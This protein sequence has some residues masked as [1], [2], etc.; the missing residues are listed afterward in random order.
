MHKVIPSPT[1][2]IN[3]GEEGSHEVYPLASKVERK[4]PPGKLEPS[5]SCC[6][7]SLPPNSSIALPEGV[8]VKKE[9]CFSAV[10]PI[11]G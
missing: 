7:N 9:S 11:S 4:P 6:A 5:G 3:A 8:I 1:S 10:L 2:R